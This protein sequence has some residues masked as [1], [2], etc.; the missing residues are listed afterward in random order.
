MVVVRLVQGAPETAAPDI[1]APWSIIKLEVELS[2]RPSS[3]EILRPRVVTSYR[4]AMLS[5]CMSPLKFTPI[6]VCL[7][8]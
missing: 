7:Y 1:L 4:N 3:L 6:L 8:V 5:A 2:D